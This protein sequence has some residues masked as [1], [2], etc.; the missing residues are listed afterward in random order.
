MNAELRRLPLTALRTF[1]AAARLLS[2]KDAADELCVSAT[3]V[4]NQIR[5]LEQS[6]QTKLFIRH[7]RAVSLTTQG[8]ALSQVV[9]RAFG[10]IRT[11]I[12]SNIL[13]AG[14]KVT[15]AVGPMFG[16]HWLIPR[17]ALF[18]AAH[19]EIDLVVT[20]GSR[21][22]DSEEMRSDIMVDW[23][24]GHWPGL[25]AH[26]LLDI[27][28]APVA[29]PDL[30]RRSKAIGL[31][32]YEFTDLVQGPILHQH[33]RLD[34]SDWCAVAG[35]GPVVFDSETVI[36]D[37]SFVLQAALDAQGIALGIFPL[38]QGEIDDGRLVRLTD[39][40]LAPQRSFY[41]L[42]RSGKAE[43][44]LVCIVCDWLIQQAEMTLA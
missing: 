21:L 30:I 28:Y 34:W 3:T 5:H 22:V 15:L 43:I 37:S 6:W 7:T 41:L 14:T 24:S 17:L 40:D 26:R 16:S 39:I 35:L 33:D 4:S 31:D 20:H 9:T 12:Q 18:R 27:V 29:S 11:E 23:G 42:S 25:K 36:A 1:E 32:L 13:N 44:S 38:M 8:C 19:P 10:E 2:F